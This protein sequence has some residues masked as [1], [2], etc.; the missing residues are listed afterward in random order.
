MW[1]TPVMIVNF[2]LY[3]SGAGKKALELAM[4]MD[5]IAEERDANLVAAVNSMDAPLIK[6]EVS[7]PVIMQHVDAVEWG[8][9]TGRINLE[10]AKEH[11]IDGILVNH[12][13]R[14]LKISEIDY[15]IHRAKEL[16]LTTVVCAN[17]SRVAGALAFLEPDFV[18]MEPPELIGGNISVSK[19]KPE[20]ILNSLEAVKSVKD[21]PVLV[22]AGI[23]S[24]EDVSKAIELGAKGV[25][26]A[27]GVVKANDPKR[28]IN[29]LIDGM[30]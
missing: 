1:G 6:K 18:A 24:K 13:E 21:I 26:V 22:G 3:P 30:M 27:S 29:D 7:I 14:M 15:L 2:K 23:K 5:K 12:S 16:G 9:H 17:N 28:V 25:L 11:E 20:A 8:A 19:A 4:L 10:L